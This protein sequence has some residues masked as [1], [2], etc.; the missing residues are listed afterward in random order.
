VK[1]LEVVLDICRFL[2]GFVSNAIDQLSPQ[3]GVPPVELPKH[4]H[5]KAP[6]SSTIAALP[7]EALKA[8]RVRMF[9]RYR[10]QRFLEPTVIQRVAIR[11]SPG[12]IGDDRRAGAAA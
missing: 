3:N 1:L 9:S 2:L 12:E 5:D 4:P 10:R 6:G 11:D 8:L 7:T